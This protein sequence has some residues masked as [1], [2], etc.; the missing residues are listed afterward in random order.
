MDDCIFCKIARKEINSNIVFEDED[1]MVIMDIN[2]V[3]DGHLLCIPKKHYKTVYDLPQNLLV[4]SYEIAYDMLEK[5]KKF[6]GIEGASFSYNY[7]AMQEILHVHMHI[8]P[9]FML[10]PEKSIEEVYQILMDDNNEKVA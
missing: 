5:I 7:G 10:K 6:N 3:C 1:F 9:N 8:M 4:K 2:P